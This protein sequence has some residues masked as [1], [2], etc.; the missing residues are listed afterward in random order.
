MMAGFVL[1]H[2]LSMACAALLWANDD[3][4]CLSVVLERFRA[5]L[6]GLVTL[7]A[8][9]TYCGMAALFPLFDH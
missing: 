5:A 6:V 3:R 2:L 8:G 4:D 9:D 1:L 7:E